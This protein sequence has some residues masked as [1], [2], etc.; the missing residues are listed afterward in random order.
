MYSIFSFSHDVMA[1]MLEL[2][3]KETAGMLES[4]P[5]SLG[6]QPYYYANVFLF[7]LKNMAVDHVSENQQ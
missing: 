1:D 2:L 3:K 6:I 7:S 4:R 5:N